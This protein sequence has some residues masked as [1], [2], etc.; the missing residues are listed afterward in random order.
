MKHKKSILESLT[1][2]EIDEITE[3]AKKRKHVPLIKSQQVN[4]RLDSANLEKAQVLA[5]LQGIPYT[6]FLSQLL[7]EDLERLWSVYNKTKKSIALN[8]INK[9]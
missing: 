3:S 1:T 8:S 5:K 7:R 6:T 9:K 4:M 2:K